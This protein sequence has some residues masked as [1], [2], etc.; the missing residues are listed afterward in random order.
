MHF[1]LHTP[2]PPL[3]TLHA[4]FP[5]QHSTFFILH[6][7]HS[8]PF[9]IPQST[10]R[11]YGNKGKMGK[12]TRLLK[13]MCFAK[14]LYMTAF[15]FVWFLLFFGENRWCSHSMCKY[16]EIVFHGF[17]RPGEHRIFAVGWLCSTRHT[18][19]WQTWSDLHRCLFQPSLF[20]MPKLH[21]GGKPVCISQTFSDV[22]KLR[23]KMFPM[24]K[25]NLIQGSISDLSAPI[26]RNC[27]LK[28]CVG[29]LEPT[30]SKWV[31][32]S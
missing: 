8:T 19:H 7:L 24:I 23:K 16:G 22:F 15:G 4:T 27:R 29:S 13:N 28:C 3:H 9:H 5:T 26:I 11:L 10:E 18:A 31:H 30:I 21:R 32:F 14:V 17:A 2:Q 1:T 25:S 20:A 12:R 6:T